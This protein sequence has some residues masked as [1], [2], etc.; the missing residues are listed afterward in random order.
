MGIVGHRP[1]PRR[2]FV[3][4]G[5]GEG[6]LPFGFVVTEGFTISC[7][8]HQLSVIRRRLDAITQAL[9]Q[10]P[11]AIE[12]IVKAHIPRDGA[13]VKENIEVTILGIATVGTLGINAAIADIL[14]LAIQGPNARR[15][16]GGQDHELNT[17]VNQGRHR[18]IINRR[19][20]QP[21][22]FRKALEAGHEVVDAPADLGVFVA[23]VG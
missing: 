4:K 6:A 21:H 19:L 12:N 18:R 8:M 2:K 10:I 7:T 9:T 1:A 13:I 14:P 17:F 16:T 23:I 11:T 5:I 3:D 15:L 20:C 22:P